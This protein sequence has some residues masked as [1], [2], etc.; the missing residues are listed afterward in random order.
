MLDALLEL[1]RA[2][3]VR[4]QSPRQ[5]WGVVPAAVRRN[6]LVRKEERQSGGLF[7]HPLVDN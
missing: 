7:R 5:Y 6:Q 3:A 4:C 1:E 2:A